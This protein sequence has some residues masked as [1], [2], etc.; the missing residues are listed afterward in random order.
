MQENAKQTE[1]TLG[2]KNKRQEV[3]GVEHEFVLYRG[4]HHGFAVR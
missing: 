4:A 2:A 1:E 3:A